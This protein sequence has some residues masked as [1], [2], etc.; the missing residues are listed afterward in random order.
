[1]LDKA[2]SWGTIGVTKDKIVNG[3]RIWLFLPTYYLMF[4]DK[5][6]KYDVK[7][8][9]GVVSIHLVISIFITFLSLWSS[10]DNDL[11]K[12]MKVLRK[13]TR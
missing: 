13:N 6:E 9:F 12:K 4:S 2:K 1:M 5:E 8:K 3:V 7:L 11:E 10:L